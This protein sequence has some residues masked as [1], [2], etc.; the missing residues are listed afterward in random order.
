M[1][2]SYKF[3]R[4]AN[5]KQK[6]MFSK[7]LGWKTLVWNK[8]LVLRETYYKEYK[9]KSGLNY[10]NTVGLLNGLEQ[11]KWYKGFFKFLKYAA[12][13]QKIFKQQIAS[14]ALLSREGILHSYG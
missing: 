6:R 1:F 8:I 10:C 14:D 5:K 13:K 7:Y 2:M 3:R 9:A 11:K 4:G 12:K